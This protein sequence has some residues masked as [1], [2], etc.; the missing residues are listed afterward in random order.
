MRRV[1]RRFK[2]SGSKQ[3]SPADEESVA[4]SRD[5]L[6]MPEPANTADTGVSAPASRGPSSSAEG[7]LQTSQSTLPPLNSGPGPSKLTQALSM[8][9]ESKRAESIY[10][11]NSSFADQSLFSKRT[12]ST[13]QSTI[14]S[15][16]SSGM[17]KRAVEERIRV[18]E[19]SSLSESH[20]KTAVPIPTSPVETRSR[21][22][23]GMNTMGMAPLTAPCSVPE[24]LVGSYA[25]QTAGPSSVTSKSTAELPP[26]EPEAPES[27]ETALKALAN[28]LETLFSSVD[29][30]SAPRLSGAMA[31]LMND[32]SGLPNLEKNTQSASLE[33]SE[34]LNV[35]IRC[36][37][38]VSDNLLRA[39][40]VRN[41]K[42]NLLRA[43]YRLGV[44]LGL[45]EM[46]IGA[47]PHPRNWALGTR[48]TPQ[49]EVVSQLIGKLYLSPPGSIIEQEGAYVAPVLRG[50]SPKFSVATIC[51][52]IP[53]PDESILDSV[54][55]LQSV[56]PSI[57]VYGR[58]DY[59]RTCAGDFGGITPPYRQLGSDLKPPM[60][61]SIASERAGT[62]SGTLGGYL[63][64]LIEDENDDLKG[65]TFA[66]TCGHVCLNTTSSNSNSSSSEGN[67]ALVPSPV[68]VQLF[69]K[70]LIDERNKHEVESI[71][72]RGYQNAL[73]ELEKRPPSTLGRVVWGERTVVGGM[74]SDISIIKCNNEFQCRNTLGT[75][76]NLSQYDPGLMFSNLTVSEVVAK[77]APGLPVFKYGSTSRY[78]NGNTSI[79]RIVYWSSG[80]VQSSEF[81]VNSD[82]PVF[83][84]GGDSGAWILTKAKHGLGAV[85]MLHS[86]DGEMKEFGL[87]TP[88]PVILNR[89]QQV[90]G[91]QWGVVGVP[92]PKDLV[93]ES[94]L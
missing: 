70:A 59:L 10:S 65:Y 73:S 67:N 55:A 47:V 18:M 35:I 87:Y 8:L 66:I 14:R 42:S 53:R 62:V 23:T 85:G 90:T 54:A 17:S 44:A 22:I 78:T 28:N 64:P 37:L 6:E 25:R 88:M 11:D 39:P 83:A 52:G 51:F 2:D 91:V 93:N 82:Q 41:A 4:P 50:F 56:V 38:G 77:A 1:L 68:L 9:P 72:Y 5:S 89:L 94:V 61:M 24:S 30:G 75:D 43:L 76:L 7:S 20:G 26:K 92:H 63:Y 46:H 27:F 57:H 45:L 40:M 31:Q 48:S 13:A 81:V 15:N 29:T 33:Q 79:S 16:L 71:E 84:T 36:V 74:L 34:D 80:K 21:D 49:D 19:S 60:S 69:R 58:M 32:F 12:R 86:Y 3:E